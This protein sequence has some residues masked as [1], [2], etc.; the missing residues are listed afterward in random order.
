MRQQLEGC[1]HKPR[2]AGSLQ[3]LEGSKNG[4]SLRAPET[5]AALDCCPVKMILDFQLQEL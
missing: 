1:G 4:F 2:N 3:N 5:S